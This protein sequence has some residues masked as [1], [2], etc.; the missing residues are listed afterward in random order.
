MTKNRTW[1]NNPGLSTPSLLGISRECGYE[2]RKGV[3]LL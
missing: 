1:P 3:A 2:L